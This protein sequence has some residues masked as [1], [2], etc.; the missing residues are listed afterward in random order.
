[1][2]PSNALELNTF[3]TDIS[4]YGESDGQAFASANGG[5][6]PYSFQWNTFQTDSFISNLPLGVYSV[7]VTDAN[8]CSS[9]DGFSVTQPT[10]I[11]AAMLTT[12][13]NCHG[14]ADGTAFVDVNGGTSPYT[15]V[16]SDGQS[17]QT[18]ENLEE[19]TYTVTIIDNN[20]CQQFSS[21]S[22]FE[23]GPTNL[24]LFSNPSCYGYTNGTAE[25]NVLGG[26]APFLY[27]WKESGNNISSSTVANGLSANINYIIEVTDGDNCLHTDSIKL[28]QPD[29]VSISSLSVNDVSR[30]GGETGYAI[31]TPIG[32]TSPTVST[33]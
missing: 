23:P 33:E 6:P 10:N 27:N 7:T 8:N 16:W 13:V 5:T 4:C 28:Y 1:M 14:G 19:G 29:L 32:G 24:Q 17:N 26:S 25:V 3:K 11:S 15:F 22:I 9:F 12:D 31:A 30:H 20:G 2:E 18:A 21:G